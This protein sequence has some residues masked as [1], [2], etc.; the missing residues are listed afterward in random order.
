[1]I[2]QP[3]L[4]PP[5]PTIQDVKPP[6]QQSA[7]RMGERLVVSGHHLDGDHATVRF[8]HARSLY[9]LELPASSDATSMEIIIPPDPAPGTV[10]PD[11]PENPDNWEIGIYSVCGIISRTAHPERTTNEL[12]VVL[13]PLISS[14]SLSVTDGTVELTLTCSPKVW[15]NQIVTLVVGDREI[16]AEPVIPDKTDTLV[17]RSASLLSGTQWVRLRVDGIDSILIDRSGLL[18]VFNSSEQVEI[19]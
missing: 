10:D 16:T 7:I 9:S 11:S 12:S 13:A 17:F 1:M 2:T 3:D 6:D 15:K 4:L 5:F 19:P 8:T 14:I 18:P